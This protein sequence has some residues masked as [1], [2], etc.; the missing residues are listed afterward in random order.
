M[1]LEHDLYIG[2][3]CQDIDASAY[4]VFLYHKSHFEKRILIVFIVSHTYNADI[5]YSSN[6]AA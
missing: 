2:T 5:V 3:K 4:F 6:Q 1:F